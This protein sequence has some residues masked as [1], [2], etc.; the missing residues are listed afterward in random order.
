LTE[1]AIND[2]NTICKLLAI[3]K[4]KKYRNMDQLRNKIML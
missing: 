2:N 3:G 4:Y 1:R